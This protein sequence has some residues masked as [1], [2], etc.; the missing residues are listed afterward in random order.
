MKTKQL[1]IGFITAVLMGFLI[2]GIS[3]FAGKKE[4]NYHLRDRGALG[5][6]SR[7]DIVYYQVETPTATSKDGTIRRRRT[8]GW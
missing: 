4:L 1:I 2:I 5:A 8:A 3:G 7:A 6:L